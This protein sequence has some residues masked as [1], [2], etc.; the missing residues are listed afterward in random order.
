MNLQRVYFVLIFMLVSGLSETSR[1]ENQAAAVQK[2]TEYSNVQCEGAYPHHLQ[3]ICID[4]QGHIFWSFTTELVKTNAA[5]KV[6]VK[7]PVGNHH[8][9]LCFQGG[10]LFVAVN[11]GDFNNPQGKA[12][13]WVYVYDAEKL[14]LIA[15]H[16]T[17]EVIYGAGGIAV[18]AGKFIVVGGLPKGIE[19]NYLYEYDPNFKFV[20]KHVLKSGYTL[21]GI[22]TAAFADN[23]WWF[24]CYGTKLLKAD[25]SYQFLAKFDLECSLGIDRINDKLLL[26]ARGG[27]E[28][29][30]HTGRVLLAEPTEKQGFI[31]RK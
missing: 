6:L 12:D 14:L 25:T 18:H 10:K 21:L 24:G 7:I 4:G 8:G 31:I 22:Q 2:K 19:E 9:D 30:L 15:K 13:S 29:K 20:K 28:G 17:P 16:Q 3:G 26:I 5:G 1:A 11:F 27:R 23:Q